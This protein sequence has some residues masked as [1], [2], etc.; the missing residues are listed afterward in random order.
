MIIKKLKRKKIHF[1]V[2]GQ[3]QVTIL[4]FFKYLFM[5]IRD[6][7]SA[8]QQC[9]ILKKITNP[10][11]ESPSA[12]RKMTL[13]QPRHAGWPTDGICPLQGRWKFTIGPIPQCTRSTHTGDT[14]NTS[15]GFYR[16][17]IRWDK[18]NDGFDKKKSKSVTLVCRVDF[19]S[20]HLFELVFLWC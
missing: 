18:N 12:M 13:L 6:K 17:F 5:K 19:S 14:L 15:N 11:P 7:I 1:V 4:S 8:P 2:Q 10:A 9:A 3:K 16:K 20:S